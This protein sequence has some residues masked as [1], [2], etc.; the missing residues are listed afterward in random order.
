MGILTA[1]PVRTAHK[2]KTTAGIVAVLAAGSMASHSD[3]LSWK[4]KHGVSFVGNED[5]VRY[6]HFLKIKDFVQKHNARYAAGLETYHVS[7]N[8]FAAMPNEEFVE[9][10]LQKSWDTTTRDGLVTEY[11][12]PQTHSRESGHPASHSWKGSQVTGVKDQ[13][14]CGS[15]WT[16]GAGAAIEGA[17]CAAGMH[18]CN[19]WNGVSTQQMV[20]CASYNS[21]LNPYDNHGCSGGF[22]SNAIRYV[23]QNGGIDSW[24]SYGY[25]SGS[26]GKE[27]SCNYNSRNSVGSIS[28]CGRLGHSGDEN[29]MCD[30]IYNQGVSTVAM[31]ASGVGFQTYSGGIYNS[32]SC[33]STRLN[34]AVTATGYGSMSGGNY[35]EVKNS[36]GSSWGDHGY[37]YI[38]RDGSNM[39]GVA[40]EGQWVIV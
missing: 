10:Y 13:G 23:I 36:W 5:R 40:S 15:C 20:D 39:C 2:M 21:D 26:N 24:D 18:N 7:L 9:K 12:C 33:S 16:F 6:G 38:A 32:K 27:H 17:M 30:M 3:W 8:K 31:D 34:H 37:I 1:L 14:S 22:Q 28:N 4:A 29:L 11:Q 25:T 35:F 19:N